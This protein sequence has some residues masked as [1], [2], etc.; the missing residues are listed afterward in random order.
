MVPETVTKIGQAIGYLLQQGKLPA[1]A[2]AKKVVIG[3]DT[4]LS[5]YMIEQALA[6][7]LNS[8]GVF[9]QL[10]GPLPTPAIG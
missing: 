3:K 2:I 9:V 10:V 1:R 4:R 8:M 5:G 6:S 7:G